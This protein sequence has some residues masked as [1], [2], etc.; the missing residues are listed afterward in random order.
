MTRAATRRAAS[1]TSGP[2][3]VKDMP[4]SPLAR[5]ATFPVNPPGETFGE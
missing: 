2:G 4:G 5:S 1:S 3:T